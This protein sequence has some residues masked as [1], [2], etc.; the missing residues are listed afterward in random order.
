MSSRVPFTSSVNPLPTAGGALIYLKGMS[1]EAQIKVYYLDTTSIDCNDTYSVVEA[2]YVDA[3]NLRW[4]Y[5]TILPTMM[6][7][8][9]S[10]DIV[11]LT[12]IPD[13][14]DFF[15][16]CT[17]QIHD[18]YCIRVLH[19]MD[20]VGKWPG[21]YNARGSIINDNVRVSIALGSIDPRAVRGVITFSYDLP[22]ARLL[23][24]RG[25]AYEGKKIIPEAADYIMLEPAPADWE[26]APPS[27]VEALLP[28]G[29]PASPEMFSV[30][31]LRKKGVHV[32]W[33]PS[34]A[35]ERKRRGPKM[36]KAKVT[37][38]PVRIGFNGAAAGEEP[39][40]SGGSGAR[41]GTRRVMR[42]RPGSIEGLLRLQRYSSESQAANC[43][44][45]VFDFLDEDANA[46][47]HWS[48][49]R[50][51]L[52]WP[53]EDDVAEIV[54]IPSDRS[55]DLIFDTLLDSRDEFV[56][57]VSN[58]QDI[59]G[60]FKYLGTE[61]WA[62]I[63]SDHVEAYFTVVPIIDHPA[64]VNDHVTF[65]YK[66]PIERLLWRYGPKIED[67]E[68]LPEEGKSIY[69]E[70]LTGDDAATLRDFPRSPVEIEER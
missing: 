21:G 34:I 45:V 62:K 19:G 25:P 28:D 39:C 15:L 8:P 56:V 31:A 33:A 18:K 57:R 67:G 65:R 13:E 16:G 58:G 43:I 69:L 6:F 4:R 38:Q 63:Q 36:L 48:L 26:G 61:L 59:E 20:I 64:A 53:A 12:P 17:P 51:F 14:Y 3:N 68:T 32:P 52:F 70:P 55:W 7:F 11:T 47:R 54:T 50:P 24:R 46:W 2:L 5:W 44:G 41:D 27:P 35:E 29:T 37:S 10:D 1:L 40:W 9:S 30:K 22:I 66:M 42:L 23:W 49:V 60:H